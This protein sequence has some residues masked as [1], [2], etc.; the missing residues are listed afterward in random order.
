MSAEMAAVLW[1]AVDERASFLTEAVRIVA[2]ENGVADALAGVFKL[3]LYI[4]RFGE[5][6]ASYW[7]RLAD[8]YE[9]ERVEN[10]RAIGRSL[11]CWDAARDRFEQVAESRQLGRDR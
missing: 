8:L 4:E 1:A 5:D 6:D 3:V 2:E 9:L 11:F 10:G 7:R